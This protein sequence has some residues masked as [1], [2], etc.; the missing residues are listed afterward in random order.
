MLS[1]DEKKQLERPALETGPKTVYRVRLK[2]DDFIEKGFMV[3]RPYL[4]EA[5]C[6]GT[7]RRAAHAWKKS[8]GTLQRVKTV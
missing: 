6:V 1:E 4:E 8:C 3:V 7:Q 2:R 5:V